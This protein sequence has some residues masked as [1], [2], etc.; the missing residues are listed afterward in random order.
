MFDNFD[1][2]LRQGFKRRGPWSGDNELGAIQGLLA[3]DRN[4]ATGAETSSQLS[5]PAAFKMSEMGFPEVWTLT[6]S[7]PFSRGSLVTPKDILF[8]VSARIGLGTGGGSQE[9]IVD[10]ENGMSM[11]AAL[12]SVSLGVFQDVSKID[13]DHNVY[14]VPLDLNVAY[15]IARGATQGGSPRRTIL[16]RIQDNTVAEAAIPVLPIP[17]FASHVSL[18]PYRPTTFNFYAAGN[19]LRFYGSPNSAA[20]QDPIGFYQASDLIAGIPVPIPAGSSG[21]SY[22]NSASAVSAHC[23]LRFAISI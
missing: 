15:T 9:V 2:Y 20:L 5:E 22:Y 10:I 13:T 17:V 6:L 16:Y 21:I 3:I 1:K 18:I 14:S 23:H 12:N 8:S 11:T 7:P 4:Q 19:Q